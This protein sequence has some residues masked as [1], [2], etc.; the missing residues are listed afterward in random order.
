MRLL[1]GLS[2]LRHRDFALYWIGQCVSQVGTFIELTATTY[3]LYAITGSP[4]LLGLGG[5]VRG[6]PILVLALFGGALADRID[7]KRLLLYTQS[8]QVATSIILGTLVATGA[9]QFWHIYVIGFV[10][11]TL[12]AFDAPARNSFYPS[13]IPRADFQNAV[14]LS[15]VIFRLSTL[16]GP[17]IA[18]IL[19]A[20]AGP[21]SPFFVNAASYFAIIF[22]LLLIRTKIPAVAGPRSSLRSAAWGGIQ[23]A[24]QSPVLPLILATEAALS[25]FG[26]NSALITIFARDVLHVGPDGL[27]L[28][29]SSV[30]AG[31]IVGTVVLVATGE[32]RPKGALMIVSGSLYAVALLGFAVS[33]S[34]AL[35]M[36]VLFVLGVADSGW[37]AM[38]NTIAQLATADAYRGRVMSMITVTSRGLTSA[39]Q[40][41]TGAIVAAAGPAVG[42]AINA[43]LVG[44][45][46]ATVAL[47]SPRLRGFRS[48]T[49][50]DVDVAA[51]AAP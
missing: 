40:L 2:P 23:Y 3:L 17:A 32:V 21:A 4:L 36:A 25:I 19:I 51:P 50:V 22:A 9:V 46:V 10:N 12:S 44:L 1:P 6:V 26:H 14:T 29:L 11:S 27:G 33:T 8:A 24:I 48:S 47:R 7:R 5:L 30:G 49:H 13:L 16:L 28:L 34:F 41:E 42:A 43:V 39:A 31:A 18:G 15:S 35:S 38:R 37:G 20:T 45:S